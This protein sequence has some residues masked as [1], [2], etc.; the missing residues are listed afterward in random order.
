MQLLRRDQRQLRHAAFAVA[1][2]VCTAIAANSDA[3]AS[4]GDYLQMGRVH[5][6]NSGSEERAELGQ[7][8]QSWD[9]SPGRSLANRLADAKP[10]C[11]G[12]ECRQSQ[13]DDPSESNVIAS[14]QLKHWQNISKVVADPVPCRQSRVPLAADG[15]AVL[16]CLTVDRPPEMR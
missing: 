7:P 4:C 16:S 5:A 1:V 15:K 2:M 10:I 14:S 9:Q 13:T 8:N 3:D 12:P 11:F 6:G